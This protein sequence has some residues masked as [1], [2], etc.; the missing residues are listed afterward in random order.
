LAASPPRLPQG[1]HSTQATHRQHFPQHTRP[2]SSA[3]PWILIIIISVITALVKV[4]I[5]AVVIHPHHILS[6]SS[7]YPLH[8]LINIHVHQQQGLHESNS[9]TQRFAV[10]VSVIV[11]VS[12]MVM[13]V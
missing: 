7:A 5:I 10:I 1:I 11:S 3:L 9:I 6:I 13:V 4:I 12:G 2:A 8:I